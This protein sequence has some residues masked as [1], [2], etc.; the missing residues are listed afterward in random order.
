MMNLMFGVNWKTIFIP[1]LPVA[2]LLIR[3]TLVYSRRD[4]YKSRRLNGLKKSEWH[5]WRQTVALV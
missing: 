4:H 2:E 5:L 3:G 1:S